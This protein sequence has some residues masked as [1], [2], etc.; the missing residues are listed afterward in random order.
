MVSPELTL[1]Y[2]PA[3]RPDVLTGDIGDTVF[4]TDWNGSQTLIQTVSNGGV[5]VRSGPDRIGGS[6][7]RP[8]STH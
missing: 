3:A 7:A 8:G 4:R 6:R 5:R 2:D 1:G